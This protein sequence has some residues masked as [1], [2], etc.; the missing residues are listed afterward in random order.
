MGGGRLK[1]EWKNRIKWILSTSC[2]PEAEAKPNGFYKTPSRLVGCWVDGPVEETQS[3]QPEQCQVLGKLTW[4]GKGG[5]DSFTQSC[6]Q[7]PNCLAA[8]L[9]DLPGCDNGSTRDRKG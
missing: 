2:V 4:L 1:K 9:Q 8:P 3:G 5:V 7:C 6:L